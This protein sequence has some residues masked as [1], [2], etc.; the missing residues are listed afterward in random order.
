[1]SEQ[2]TMQAIGERLR[3]QDNRITESPMFCVQEKVR[4]Y[5]YDPAWR[6]DICWD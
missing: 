3:T 6:D 5:G 2:N 1:M 4:D